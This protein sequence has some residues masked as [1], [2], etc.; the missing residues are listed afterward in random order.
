MVVLG[1][2][3]R[4][5]L[6]IPQ[7]HTCVQCGGD[8]RVAQGVRYDTMTADPDDIADAR[9]VHH[10]RHRHR[11]VAVGQ[12]WNKRR[13]ISV[14]KGRCRLTGRGSEQA[15]RAKALIDEALRAHS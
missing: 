13:G 9:L 15:F 2:L 8:E 14:N 6:D 12:A 7:G 5:F 11:A 4:R 3:A 1:R 10:G